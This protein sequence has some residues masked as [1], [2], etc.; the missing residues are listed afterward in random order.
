M[1]TIKKGGMIERL[2][3]QVK[4]LTEELKDYDDLKKQK[5]IDDKVHRERYKNGQNEMMKLIG[6]VLTTKSYAKNNQSS[7]Y[8]KQTQ[9][10]K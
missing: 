9:M 10:K 1:V 7:Y 4:D 3:T 6:T 2:N 5:A 8:K